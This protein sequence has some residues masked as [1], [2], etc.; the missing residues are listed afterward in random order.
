LYIF[1]FGII[2]MYLSEYFAKRKYGKRDKEGRKD[3]ETEDS[4]AG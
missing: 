3:S 2:L 1:G 4:V